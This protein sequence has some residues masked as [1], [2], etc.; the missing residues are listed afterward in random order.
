MWRKESSSH[1]D[2]FDLSWASYRLGV[3]VCEN[4]FKAWHQNCQIIDIADI[5]DIFIGSLVTSA[6][7]ALKIFVRGYP[8]YSIHK[9]QSSFIHQS[10]NQPISS[11]NS[12]I[13][14][15]WQLWAWS[16]NIRSYSAITQLFK[17]ILPHFKG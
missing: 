11:M 1:D 5:A 2:D 8:D 10:I 9:L 13:C 3:S 15:I 7:A 4:P 14:T 12:S 17:E 6:L 16:T